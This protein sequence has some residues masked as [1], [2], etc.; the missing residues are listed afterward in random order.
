MRL[1]TVCRKLLAIESLESRE[2]LAKD[3][4]QIGS[5][6]DLIEY[7]DTSTSSYI[8]GD[9]KTTSVTIADGIVIDTSNPTGQAGSILIQADGVR[10][11]R[12]DY[13]TVRKH[14]QGL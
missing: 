6:N 4:I 14:S 5:P 12:V 8:I 2:L 3:T 1:K 9:E 11:R 13:P 7:F 10:A